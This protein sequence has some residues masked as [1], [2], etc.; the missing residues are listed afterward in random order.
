MQAQLLKLVQDNR[1]L[2]WSVG[3]NHLD[4][5]DE[6]V[7]VE[8]ILNLGDIKSTRKLLEIMGTDKVAQIFYQHKNQARSNYYPRVSHYF[9]LYF[10]RHAPQYS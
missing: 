1:P 9:D 6:T 2:F 8:T 4:Q 5:I 3:D 7:I 10:K